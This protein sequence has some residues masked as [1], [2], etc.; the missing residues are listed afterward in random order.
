MNKQNTYN[1]NWAKYQN[2][3]GLCRFC[4]NQRLINQKTCTT[5]YLKVMA[6][7]NLNN[8]MHHSTLYEK[9]VEQDF[10]C[11]LSGRELI[12]GDNASLD[13]VIAR[14]KDKSLC[15]DLS[16]IKW[17]DKHVNRVKTDLSVDELL[18]LCKEII[19]HN[20]IGN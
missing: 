17:I 4:N 20:E 9:L 18:I 12:L 5:C 8:R 10:K 16:N 2:E 3:K 15:L 14:S 6:K 7:N 19:K 1:N 11:Y 13:H